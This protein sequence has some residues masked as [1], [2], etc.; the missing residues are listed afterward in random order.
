MQ[1]RTTTRRA[2]SYDVARMAGVAQSTVS[3]CFQPG[4]NIS[5]AT[6]ALV[7]GVAERLGYMPNAMARSLITQRSNLVGVVATH[8][9]LRGNPDVVHAIGETLAA[10]GKQFLLI[11]AQ[12]DATTI[13][14]LRGALEYPLDG[15][16]SCVLLADAAIEEIQARGLPL[17]LFNRGSPRIAVDS[18]TTNHAAAAANVAAAL[19][20]AGHRSFLCVSG[21]RNAHVSRQRRAGFLGRLLKLGIKATPVIETD[22]SY[23]GGRRGFLD[24][25]TGKQLPDAVFCANDQVALG[26]IDACRFDLNLS[27]PD[28]VSVVGFDDI[29]EAARPSYEL[30]TLHQDSEQMARMAVDILLRRLADPEASAI[31]TVVD[32]VLVKRRSARLAA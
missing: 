13:A 19:Y 12:S 31:N 11:T 29:A 6:R 23:A 27:I 14:D 17:V 22:Y 16:I 1:R 18:V 28:D 24:G 21:P 8:Y 7:T 4:S 2:T 30:T 26:V 10:A 32:A 9:T 25:V 20:A 5:P 15:L 3:R